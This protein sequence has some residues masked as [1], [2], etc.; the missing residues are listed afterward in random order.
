MPDIKDKANFPIPKFPIQIKEVI[1][2][3]EEE[4][5]REYSQRLESPCICSSSRHEDACR[6]MCRKGTLTRFN[7]GLIE[8]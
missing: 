4:K 8:N 5:K 3:E 6:I 1:K 2:D 7:P